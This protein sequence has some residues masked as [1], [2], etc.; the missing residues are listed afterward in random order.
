[1][2]DQTA[3]NRIIEDN[4]MKSLVNGFAQV[5]GDALGSKKLLQKD[6]EGYSLKVKFKDE[7]NTE[8]T[9]SLD[10]IGQG[11]VVIYNHLK[12]FKF[13]L[14]KIFKVQGNVDVDS[15][16]DL[17]PVHIQNFKDLKPY[18]EAVEGATKHLATAITLMASK[19]PPE[20]QKAPIV[21]FDI[22]PLL[23]A[24]QELKDVSSKPVD[25]KSQI[26][27]LR[28]ISE[29]I[30][31]LNDKPT[32]VP[33][34]VDHVSINALQGLPLVTTLTVGATATTIPATNLANRRDMI[35]Y[36]NSLS[37]TLYIGDSAVTTSGAHQGLPVP[38]KSYSPSLSLGQ[39]VS[40]YG[41][42]TTNIS[43]TCLE[44]SEEAA[45]R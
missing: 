13:N 44:L 32:F 3:R 42:S 37:A 14:P 26:N 31:A 9:S 36:N 27:M 38:A 10:K 16:A 45:G 4:R 33:P 40:L 22:K 5:V 39:N 2:I 18:F 23:N 15:I 12:N 29:G 6:E 1:M 19:S 24:L 7:G 20:P 43:V 11:L 8:L 30:G 25:N 17:P 28:T 21:N 34:T 35:I 41:I